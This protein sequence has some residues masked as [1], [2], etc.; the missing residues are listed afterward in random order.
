MSIINNFI[1]M[2]LKV[3]YK[4]ISVLL[5]KL[6]VVCVTPK[7]KLPRSLCHLRLR[8]YLLQCTLPVNR[9]IHN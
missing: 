4:K 3:V 1:D 6:P 2:I 8:S 7:E 9:R 5:D